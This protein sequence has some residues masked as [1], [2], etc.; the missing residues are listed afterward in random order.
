MARVLLT[1]EL[2]PGGADPLD[3][4][5]ADLAFGLIIAASR[6]FATAEADLRAGG[7]TGFG[8]LDRLGQ[9]VHGAT[10][11]IVGYGRIGRAVARRAAGF[12]MTVLHLARHPTGE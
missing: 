3:E 8:L 9:D 5:T 12:D 6:L 2:P 10:L 1:A 4:T 11:G 7:W